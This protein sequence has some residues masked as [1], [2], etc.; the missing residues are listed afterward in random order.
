MAKKSA[1]RVTAPPLPDTLSPSQRER[2][3]RIVEAGLTLLRTHDHTQIQMKD[4]AAEAGVALGTVYRY[5]QSKDHLFAEVLA[6]WAGRL[7]GSVERRPLAGATNAERLTDVLHRSMRAFQGWPQ[8]ARVVMALE[9]SED[10]FTREIFARNMA[11]NTQIYVEA[12]QGLPDAV[13]RDVVSVAASVFDLQLR[14][15]VVGAQSIADVY[16]RITRAVWVLLEFSERLPAS[17]VA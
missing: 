1:P 15:W 7:Q 11:R 8:L 12:L 16:D 10:P 13:A 9:S 14:Q 3:E 5:F 17:S 2:R 4:V 6:F